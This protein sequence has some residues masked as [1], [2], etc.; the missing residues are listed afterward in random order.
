MAAI[1][2]SSMIVYKAENE[3]HVLSVFTDIDC[4]YCRKL[5]QEMAQMNELGITVRYLAFPRAGLNSPSYDKAVSV[6]CAGDRNAAMDSAKGSGQIEA[7]K[8]DAPVAM[9]MQVARQL[10]VNSTPSLVL[11]DGRLQPGYA[12]P[13]QLLSLFK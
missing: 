6:W 8:C 2:E 3:K 5:H 11:E 12:P 1:P 9:H 10:G 4:V 13:K 7:I